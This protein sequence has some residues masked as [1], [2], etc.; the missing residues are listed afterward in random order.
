[1]SKNILLTGSPGCGKTT[2]IK[3]VIERLSGAIDG[4]Y[5][6]EIREGGARRGFKMI[7]FDGRDGILAHVTIKSQHRIGK[8]GVDLEEL[9]AIGTSSI[10]RALENQSLMVIDEIGPMELLS[11]AFK[12]AVLAALD[13]NCPVLGTIVKRSV[14]F[15][16]RIKAR[17]DV[18]VIEVQPGNR[19][20]L[21][22]ELVTLLQAIDH[23]EAS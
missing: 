7:T 6:Q 17:D 14:P 20:A 4:F 2:L 9:D 22:D 12:E 18:T 11:A 21:V 13:S 8:Y 5:T 10:R 1:M 23:N 15:A 16:D 19:E 3:R